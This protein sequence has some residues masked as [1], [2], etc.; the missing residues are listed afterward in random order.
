MKRLL[1][2]CKK[3]V[4]LA[5][6][7]LNVYWVNKLWKEPIDSVYERNEKNAGY[8]ENAYPQKA[9]RSS[10]K[11]STLHATIKPKQWEHSASKKRCL[12]RQR[13]LCALTAPA[14]PILK[15]ADGRSLSSAP[16]AVMECLRTGTGGAIRKETPKDAK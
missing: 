7:S 8:S 11:T 1:S 10:K 16:T 12:L 15:V 14:S 5:F 6:T 9:R 2:S 4:I 3:R 13:F